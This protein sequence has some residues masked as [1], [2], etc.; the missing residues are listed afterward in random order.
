LLRDTGNNLI[1]LMVECG[2]LKTWRAG[3]EGDILNYFDY[4][5]P[6]SAETKVFPGDAGGHR[7][8]LCDDMGKSSNDSLTPGIKDATAKAAKELGTATVNSVKY[9]GVLDQDE[10]GCYA[11]LLVKL[12]GDTLMSVTIL[13]TVIRGKALFSAV[14][15]EFKGSET[16]QRGVQVS[17]T[18]A[19]GLDE[20]NP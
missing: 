7:K 3:V 14:Y 16:T 11:G 17:K 6:A 8:T 2:R 4:Y 10:H 19:L 20:K 18:T 9:L 15:D 12:Q 1:L 13:G 5:M